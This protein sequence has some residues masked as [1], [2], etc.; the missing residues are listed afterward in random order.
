M[1]LVVL[2][3]DQT[4]NASDPAHFTSSFSEPLT[5][6]PGQ[7]AELV[8]FSFE[9]TIE[10]HLNNHFPGL[11]VSVPELGT[12]GYNGTQRSVDS[13]VGFIPESHVGDFVEPTMAWTPLTAQTKVGN[14]RSW[15]K[16]DGGISAGHWDAAGAEADILVETL[17]SE[18]GWEVGLILK[19]TTKGNS[20][21][22]PAVP[23][24]TLEFE[25]MSIEND[26]ITLKNLQSHAVPVEHDEIENGANVHVVL[27]PS[28][29]VSQATHVYL[30]NNEA[31]TEAE[32][33]VLSA[34]TETISTFILQPSPEGL[35]IQKGPLDTIGYVRMGTVTGPDADAALGIYATS[36]WYDGRIGYNASE[37]FSPP[38]PLKLAVNVPTRMEV[39]ALTCIVTLLNGQ[40]ASSSSTNTPL[41]KKATVVLRLSAPPDTLSA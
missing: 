30:M 40:L 38:Y 25:I 3:S 4:P 6:F 10:S 7:T 24:K 36:V 1:S 31:N 34:E 16:V 2:S 9:K 21:V 15:D 8:S 33:R 18:L 11:L 12:R 19:V 37:T 20:G 35:V 26:E 17:G 22:V 41:L 14:N 23:A 13:V 28:D 32:I 39:N 27:D 29:D 5:L